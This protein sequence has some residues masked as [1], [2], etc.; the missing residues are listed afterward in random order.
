MR[1]LRNVQQ[2][3]RISWYLA[4]GCILNGRIMSL[5]PSKTF[6]R[7]KISKSVSK[8]KENL[9]SMNKKKRQRIINKK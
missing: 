8:E 3:P 5:P 2:E 9:F 1:F 7:Q 4:F 6:G